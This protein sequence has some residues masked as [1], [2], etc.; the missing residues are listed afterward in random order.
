MFSLSQ[1]FARSRRF[2]F[3]I[4]I[5]ALALAT[6]ASPMSASAAGGADLQ[7]LARG[8]TQKGTTTFYH[9]LI[10]NNGPD[11]AVNFSYYKEAQQ[12]QV[13]GGPGF[14]LVN[15][16]YFQATLAAGQTKA[17]TVT[18]MPPAGWKCTQATVMTLN[19]PTD[20]NGANNIQTIVN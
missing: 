16:G 18:C 7:V 1:G 15:D 20:P 9:F 12:L 11:A 2:S 8:T 14:D 17:V 4:A 13:V 3:G 5:A 10:R 19:N 6:V